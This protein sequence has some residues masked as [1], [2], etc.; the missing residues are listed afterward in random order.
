MEVAHPRLAAG[1]WLTALVLLV[2]VVACSSLLPAAGTAPRPYDIVVT[3]MARSPGPTRVII[4]YP[5]VVD[6][7]AVRAGVAQLGRRAGFTPSALAVRDGLV[8]RDL[9]ARGTDVEFGA[10][11]LVPK[12]GALPVGPIVRSIPDWEHMRLV[13]LLDEG[14]GFTGPTVAAAS[15]FAVRLV[16]QTGAYE[17]DVERTT[18]T[19]R[20]P[21]GPAA[22]PGLGAGRLRSRAEAQSADAEPKPSGSRSL[23]PAVLIGL[24]SG[25]LAG[26]LAYGWW[27]RVGRARR[28][29][30]LREVQKQPEARPGEARERGP[31]GG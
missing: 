23:L 22:P 9:A 19:G 30:T 24:P 16:N 28:S 26:W 2:A 20:P 15:G 8:A 29:R 10:A 14:Y 4:V 17:Y 27:D 7:A 12:A 1:S 21:A 13:F 5:K 31:E 11:G 6:H 3:V 18:G 25:L